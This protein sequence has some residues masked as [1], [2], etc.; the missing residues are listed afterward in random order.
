M[1]RS[2]LIVGYLLIMML[3]AV[4]C[5]AGEKPAEPS[6]TT[7]PVKSEGV[8]SMQITSTA[9]TQGESIPAEY[10]ADGANVSPP[11]NWGK[12][13][14]GTRSFALI[15]DDPDAPMGTWVH[16]VVWN[17]PPDSTG[18][19][20]AVP[21]GAGITG[22]GMQGNNSGGKDGYMGPAPPSGTHRYFFKL[23]ALDAELSLAAGS[24][25]ADLLKAMEGHIIGSG[26]LMGTYS[27]NR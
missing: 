8:V 23:Y 17:L 18:L 2:A 24:T 27:R 3:G 19:P 21:H 20:K 12:A 1:T 25:K 13:P 11:L 5:A 4:G 6:N 9:F 7:E 10:T 14:A 15:C 22:G 26:E 16:W